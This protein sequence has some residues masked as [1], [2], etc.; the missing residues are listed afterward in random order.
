M[1]ILGIFVIPQVRVEN[2]K[3][4]AEHIPEVLARVRHEYVIKTY[5]IKTWDDTTDFLEQLARRTGKLLK[6][7]NS[8][9]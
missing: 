6:V 2:V 7:R 4:A 5:K 3:E 9:I 1:F 8:L